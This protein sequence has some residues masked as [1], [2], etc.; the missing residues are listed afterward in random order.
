MPTVLVGGFLVVHGL[1]TTMIGVGRIA[2]P[3]GPAMALP[4]WMDWWPGSLG[5]SWLIDG[6]HVGST[7][8]TVGSLVW[9]AAGVLLAAA[10]L[11]FLG[12]PVLTDSWPALAGVGAALGLAALILYFHPFYLGAVAINVVLLAV[13]WG[14]AASPS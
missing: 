8:S 12:A 1:I 3:K 11:G 4:G 13:V 2:D 7:G 10:G 6:L 14:G 9:V 5:R